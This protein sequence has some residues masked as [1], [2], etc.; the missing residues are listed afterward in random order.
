MRKG[1]RCEIATEEEGSEKSVSEAE[2][3]F[4]RLEEIREWWP[5]FTR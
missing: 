5:R 1:R 2:D 3:T 4:L